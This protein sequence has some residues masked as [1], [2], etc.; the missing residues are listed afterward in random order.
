MADETTLVRRGFAP[1][2]ARLGGK[3]KGS[4]S[5]V[6]ELIESLGPGADPIRFLALLVRD[7][8][9]QSTVITPD[10]KRR[11]VPEAAP[12][13][14]LVESAKILAQYYVPKLTAIAHTNA[15]HD[16]PVE[17]ETKSLHA[18]M[19]DPALCEAAQKLALAMCEID[20]P[21]QLPAPII[22][23]RAPE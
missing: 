6:R 7:K 15:E 2:H 17:V 16:G 21:K 5:R 11:K 19:A 14:M 10:G 8:C 9:Y 18:I 12:L 13:S 22:G 3:G 1:G 4:A 20:A 23:L